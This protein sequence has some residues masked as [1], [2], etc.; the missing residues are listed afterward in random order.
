MPKSFTFPT[1]I[2]EVKTLSV[3]C[4]IR[5]GYLKPGSHSSG[6]VTWSRAGNETGSI[7]IAVNTI[8]AKPYTEL[9]YSHQDTPIR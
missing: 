3:S 5:W 6:V 9:D 8:T 7:S 2:D 4:L 1:L